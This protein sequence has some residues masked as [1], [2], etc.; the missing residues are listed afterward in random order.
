MHRILSDVGNLMSFLDYLI[1]LSLFSHQKL[2]RLLL[3]LDR[4]WS[5]WAAACPDLG[6]W[7]TL[8]QTSSSISVSDVSQQ[9]QGL[10]LEVV[11]YILGE[12]ASYINLI[13]DPLFFSVLLSVVSNA[14]AFSRRGSDKGHYSLIASHG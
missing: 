6:F 11:E 1:G 9:A 8:R 2:L 10:C 14:L 4:V 5:G 3:L 12:V 7:A 13:S